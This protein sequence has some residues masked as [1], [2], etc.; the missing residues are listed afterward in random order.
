[1]TFNGTPADFSTPTNNTTLVATVPEAFTTGPISITTPAGTT[2][3]GTLWFYAL[4]VISSFSP[5]N[6]LP[7]TN[8]V[9]TGQSFLG[10]TAVRFNGVT[11]A[12]TP[13][14]NNT[15]L[16]ATV[17]AG[18]QTGPI[19]VV[20]PAGTNASAQSF[21]LDYRS[22][23][24]LTGGAS[25]EP[26]TVTSNLTYTV[27]VSNFGPHP[28]PNVKLTNH[29]PASVTVQSVLFPGGTLETNGN[30]V[31]GTL[32]SLNSGANMTMILQ[33]RPNVAGSITNVVEVGSGY[34]DPY[35]TNNSL[36]L[37]SAVYPLPLLSI[38]KVPVNRF[39][40]SWPVEWTNYGLQYSSNLL[41]TNGWSNITSAPIISGAERF[42]L[43]T[44]SQPMRF[45]RLKQ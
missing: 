37:V 19:S 31:V 45:Y 3:S 11:A 34:V 29:L 21:V 28:A 32:P 35:V 33:V 1:V 17:P 25:P 13:P 4:P 27:Q 39:R 6:G 30:A 44:N 36:V 38:M 43:E 15:T 20:A 23:L 5:T 9:L 41:E 42:V 12:F 16:V 2:N 18:A 14:T 24:R 7:G 22:D 8:V 40:I 10:T 26:V